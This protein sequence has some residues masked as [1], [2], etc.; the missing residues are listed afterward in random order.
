M[1]KKKKKEE[2]IIS[3]LCEFKYFEALWK[4]QSI[5]PFCML[6]YKVEIK[7]AMLLK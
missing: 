3:F 4:V 6:S 1:F 5:L 7:F 2:E